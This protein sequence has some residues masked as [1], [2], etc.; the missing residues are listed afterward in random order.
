[1]DVWVSLPIAGVEVYG[2]LYIALGLFGG[3]ISTFL[4]IGS[5]IL[6]TPILLMTEIPSMIAVTSQ[7]YSSVG[8]N[9]IGVLGHWRSR[10]VD[11]SMAWYI[12]LGG[13]AGALTEAFVMQKFGKGI[14]LNRVYGCILMFLAGGML[15]QYIR[16]ALNPKERDKHVTM[17]EWMIYVPLHRIFLRSRVEVSILIPLS[18]GFLIGIL[19]RTLGGG[20]N[21][22]AIP[23]L[24]YLLGR[25][26]P[27]ITG[28]SLLAGSS[29]TMFVIFMQSL[30]T[31]VG[32]IMLIALLL[33]GSFVGSQIALIVKPW[34]PKIW[35][36]I[37]GGLTVMLIGGQFF[38]NRTEILYQVHKKSHWMLAYANQPGYLNEAIYNFAFNYPI[39]YGATIL[40]LIATFA[41]LAEKFIKD[42]LDR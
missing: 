18:V 19:T 10:S 37:L 22:L 33:S 21:L 35:P 29:I 23:V 40:I 8:T 25:P 13:V 15:I 2:P 1:M 12:F 41:G 16:E 42:Y 32:D 4:G 14:G 38:R 28:T 5:G 17:H 26:S 31:S 36:A 34:I 24:S 39:V 11:V 3:F 9:L 20:G 30:D 7:L 6:V 27:V